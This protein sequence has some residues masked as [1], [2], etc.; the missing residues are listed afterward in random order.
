MVDFTHQ[1]GGR[2]DAV[3][4]AADSE[5]GELG[6]LGQWHGL[7]VTDHADV[8]P[9]RGHRPVGADKVPAEAQE[10]VV[11]VHAA[12]A[13]EPVVGE[14]LVHGRGHVGDA[15]VARAGQRLDFK[16]IS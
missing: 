3:D 13:L 7:G 4:E 16:G 8:D 2:R 5:R 6:P 12:G 14:L 11:L 9:V 15:G 1:A 10:A